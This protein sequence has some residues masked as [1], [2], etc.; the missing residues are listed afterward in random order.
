MIHMGKS[1]LKNSCE[2]FLYKPKYFHAFPTEW[3]FFYQMLK[4]LFYE[5]ADAIKKK[6]KNTR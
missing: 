5:F 4:V 6:Q 1:A 3:L 2:H